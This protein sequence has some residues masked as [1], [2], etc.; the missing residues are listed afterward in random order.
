M[1][2]YPFSWREEQINRKVWRIVRAFLFEIYKEVCYN[3]IVL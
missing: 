1:N 3:V 2:K